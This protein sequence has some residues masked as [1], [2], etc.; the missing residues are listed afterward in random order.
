MLHTSVLVY[1]IW[2]FILHMWRISEDLIGTARLNDNA[3]I[4]R[5]GGGVLSAHMVHGE[6]PNRRFSK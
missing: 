6:R 3:E 2:Q 1:D 5:L 4:F